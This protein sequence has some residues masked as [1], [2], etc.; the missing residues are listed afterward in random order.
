MPQLS[1]PQPWEV[2]PDAHHSP[3]A[4]DQTTPG[5][6]Q[7]FTSFH[8]PSSKL[9]STT[10]SAAPEFSLLLSRAPQYLPSPVGVDHDG[11]FFRN[12]VSEGI[13]PRQGQGL[14][15][16]FV[17][18]AT[19]TKSAH[20]RSILAPLSNQSNPPT[21]ACETPEKLP[22]FQHCPTGRLRLSNIQLFA[23]TTPT[24]T[25]SDSMRHTQLQSS[26]PK[27]RAAGEAISPLSGRADG[28]KRIFIDGELHRFASHVRLPDLDTARSSNTPSETHSPSI[29]NTHQ[30]SHNIVAD[31][32]SWGR[33]AFAGSLSTPLL[34]PSPVSP[35]DR[36]SV[37]T[38][39]GRRLGL[40]VPAGLYQAL[41]VASPCKDTVKSPPSAHPHDSE[42]AG[43]TTQRSMFS[44]APSGSRRSFPSGSRITDPLRQS[45]EWGTGSAE[46][47]DGGLGCAFAVPTRNSLPRVYEEPP[48][49]KQAGWSV[50]SSTAVGSSRIG[51]S[52]ART[53]PPSA[54][55][56][57]AAQRL[58]SEHWLNSST[59]LD[60]SLQNSMYCSG[61]A[62][63]MS[64][65]SSDSLPLG[66]PIHRP[67]PTSTRRLADDGSPVKSL[68]T[69]VPRPGTAT[70]AERTVSN[71]TST[72][73]VLPVV[74]VPTASSIGRHLHPIHSRLG[75]SMHLSGS[76]GP[77]FFNAAPSSSSCNGSL[78]VFAGRQP[79]SAL[80]SKSTAQ[81]SM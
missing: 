10:S 16:A 33:L 14:G 53:V 2:L 7:S 4:E 52:S 76:I 41:K 56:T 47:S 18:H 63:P 22:S 70:D 68:F 49:V 11:D 62:R 39:H 1:P 36:L 78:P 59:F 25:S 6:L 31:S 8:H 21:E 24:F 61:S 79:D 55:G 81:G 71:Q 69:V 32:G 43:S 50:S 77:A 30:P 54:N 73:G 23:A 67:V 9:S 80:G 13:P 44:S 29:Q 48:V 45:D 57:P 28:G 66:R 72:R 75:A 12:T 40:Q 60:F 20:G 51:N 58:G 35:R 42:L 3:M 46:G 38:G 65:T 37:D 64:P 26:E 74:A 19:A 15:K 27:A 5:H 17:S 34:G